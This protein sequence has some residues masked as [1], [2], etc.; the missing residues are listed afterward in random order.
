VLRAVLVLL[1]FSWGLWAD[2]CVPTGHAAHPAIVSPD[3]RYRLLNLLCASANDKARGAL[4]LADVH[5]GTSRTV[6]TYDRDATALWSPDS[7]HIA[8]NDYAGSNLTL[9]PV[10][11]VDS[12]GSSI[13][14]Q[15]QVVP[16]LNSRRIPT[17]DHLYMSVTRWLSNDEVELVVWGHGAGRGFCKAY[18]VRLSGGVGEREL[19]IVGT[20]PEGYCGK[21]AK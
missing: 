11:S 21:L 2:E 8:V 13:D 4:V 1:G 17:D 19:R 7:Q 20:D 5:S 10:L 9:N 6:Y 18:S 15:M 12:K 16:V 3:G 14:L